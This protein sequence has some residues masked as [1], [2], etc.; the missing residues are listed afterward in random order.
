MAYLWVIDKN[1]NISAKSF[2]RLGSITLL[3]FFSLITV[4]VNHEASSVLFL[5]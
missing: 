4:V 1:L 3:P 5:R 2:A